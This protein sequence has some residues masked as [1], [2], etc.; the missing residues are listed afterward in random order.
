MVWVSVST[1]LDPVKYLGPGLC[2][3][4]GHAASVRLYMKNRAFGFG[5]FSAQPVLDSYGKDVYVATSCCRA[6]M[7][8][9]DDEEARGLY[10][11]LRDSLWDLH[12]A[13]IRQKYPVRDHASVGVSA[14]SACDPEDPDAMVLSFAFTGL[15][16]DDLTPTDVAMYGKLVAAEAQEFCTRRSTAEQWTCRAKRLMQS[17]SL[18]SAL[19]SLLRAQSYDPGNVSLWVNRVLLLISLGRLDQAEID[20]N[21]CLDAWPDHQAV[22]R[23][24]SELMRAL[25]REDEARAHLERAVI[26]NEANRPAG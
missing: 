17:G 12:W 7:R 25:G 16:L 4:C 21:A 6:G 19:D 14:G 18:E 23:V 15:V 24:H 11:Q 26:L 8:A 10:L 5:V 9:A 1:R 22:H 13:R 20:S 3:T 2:P